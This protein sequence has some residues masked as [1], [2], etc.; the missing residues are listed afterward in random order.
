MN[1]QYINNAINNSYY[2]LLINLSKVKLFEN[3]M[4]SARDFFLIKKV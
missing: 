3:K 4:G 2:F 1:S